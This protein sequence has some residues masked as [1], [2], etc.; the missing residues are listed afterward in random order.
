MSEALTRQLGK[1]SIA[2]FT[3]ELDGLLDQINENGRL[4][5]ET[6]KEIQ[7]LRKLNDKSFE[8]MKKAVELATR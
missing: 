4:A 8:K 2:A 5:R 1:S 7:R 6:D 3:K